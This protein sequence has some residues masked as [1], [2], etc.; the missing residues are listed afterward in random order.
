MIE[1]AKSTLGATKVDNNS[2]KSIDRN[3]RVSGV[4]EYFFLVEL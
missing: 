2:A 4:K 3:G 1:M